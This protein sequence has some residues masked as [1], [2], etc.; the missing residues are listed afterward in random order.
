MVPFVDPKMDEDLPEE[1]SSRNLEGQLVRMKDLEN[2][3]ALATQE[4]DDMDEDDRTTELQTKLEETENQLALALRETQD[5]DE[6]NPEV[7]DLKKRLDDAERQLALVT[8]VTDGIQADAPAPAPAPV[9]LAPAP[10]LAPAPAPAPA[11]APAHASAPG[12]IVEVN[13]ATVPLP[14]SEDDMMYDTESDE[15]DDDDDDDDDDSDDSELCDVSGI[16]NVI[17]R[18]G[19]TR[20]VPFCL[21]PIQLGQLMERLAVVGSQ[22]LSAG[23]CAMQLQ[24][25]TQ[26]VE[27]FLR[28][29]ELNSDLS[30]R[31]PGDRFTQNNNLQQQQQQ[32]QITGM[33]NVPPNWQAYFESL[34][35][36]DQRR[37]AGI[38]GPTLVRTTQ[39]L[40]VLNEALADDGRIAKLT[41]PY[42]A[43]PVQRRQMRFS[44]A[45]LQR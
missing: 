11:A 27:D 32:Q 9:P 42:K 17:S 4:V 2:Q 20:D 10:T 44:N 37:F 1:V 6:D 8:R 21:R 31:G 41:R 28:S 40:E 7:E 13:P 16:R 15:S 26:Q 36:A 25:I 18:M 24:M 19:R 5:M 23:E 3:L 38:F 33:S 45:W 22:R 14:D 12:Q 35:K 29:N 39:E 30:S 34:S 43:Q